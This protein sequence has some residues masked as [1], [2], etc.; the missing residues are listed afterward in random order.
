MIGRERDKLPGVRVLDIAKIAQS[1]VMYEKTARLVSSM[2]V[3]GGNVKH[4]VSLIRAI[5]DRSKGDN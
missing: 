2:Q 3:H 1:D 5:A 4:S